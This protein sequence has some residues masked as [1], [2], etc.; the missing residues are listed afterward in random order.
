[1]SSPERIASR[2]V[3]LPSTV[4]SSGQYPSARTSK[5]N[6]RLS[7]TPTASGSCAEVNCDRSMCTVS[8]PLESVVKD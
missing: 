4:I 6:S 1:M 3:R 5:I 2:R 7:P 8:R